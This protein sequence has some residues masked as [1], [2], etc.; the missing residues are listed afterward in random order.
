MK[1]EA[2]LRQKYLDA[3]ERLEQGEARWSKLENVLR[4]TV[5]R[6]CLAARGRS[7]LL[8]AQLRTL[9]D[10]IRRQGEAEQIEGCL[11]PLSRAIAALDAMPTGAEPAS[12]APL[13]RRRIPQPPAASDPSGAAV[14]AEDEA[15]QAAARAQDP[16]GASPLGE[17]SADAASDSE[18][19][20]RIQ[21]AMVAM[22]ERLALLPE[23]RPALAELLHE[24][25]I[26]D[27]KADELADGL[28]RVARMVGEQRS[29][30][31]RE[32]LEIEALLRQIDARLEELGAYLAGEAAD[33]DNAQ[34]STRQLNLLV[35]DEMHELNTDVQRALDLTELR[36]R[37]RVR[38]ETI[39]THLQDF[40]A[41]EEERLSTQVDRTGR[42]R[43]R[44]AELER[45]SHNLQRTL[46]EEQRL[47][48]MDALTGIP[49]R[50]A[51][52]D[53]IEQEYLHWQQSATPI[54]ILAWDIDRFKNINDAYGHRA[55]DKVLRVIAQHLA[56]HVRGTDFVAR[57]GGEEFVMIL[58]GTAS[59][60]A[61]VAADKIRT[62]IAK[63]GF[64]FRN[65]PVTVTA[66][67]GIAMFRADDT[68]DS[69]FD[70]A[71]RA[72]YRAKE[73]GRNCCVIL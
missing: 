35:M 53:R 48:M 6:L 57:Y 26:R 61:L 16:A 39:N 18:R 36:A 65:K 43:V 69:V 44:I 42:L 54:S 31:Q 21:T 25:S 55:G 41:R 8:D 37:V 4:L 15:Q 70:R 40:R 11:D 23:L 60:Q 1:S 51:Y 52:D 22:L 73:T 67:C 12:A 29:R 7:A 2:D 38:L 34:E 59:D 45:E 32:K 58:I 64:H 24:R 28:E 47:A 62:N 19:D 33:H 68:P 49:N 9:G 46:Q 14:T 17:P 56:Q 10:L 30:M 50:A 13:E 63:I 72:L 27:L 71:D 3:L 66:S 20:A 5:G